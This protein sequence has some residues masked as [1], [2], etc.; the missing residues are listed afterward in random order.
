MNTLASLSVGL[1]PELPP[2]EPPGGQSVRKWWVSPSSA[3]QGPGKKGEG[4]E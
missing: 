3:F 1:L 4:S 2:S